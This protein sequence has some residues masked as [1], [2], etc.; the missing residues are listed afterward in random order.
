MI[1]VRESLAHDEAAMRDLFELLRESRALAGASHD[2]RT[3]PL[4]LVAN[5]RNLEVAI[6]AAWAQHLLA[7]R[8][9]VD[10]LVTDAIAS[11]A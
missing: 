7:R 3:T 6:E 8:L 2:L 5:R 11:L 9:S 1:C 10:D 4:G